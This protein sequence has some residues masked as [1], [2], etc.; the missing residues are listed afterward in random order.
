MN[1]F[2]HTQG[3]CIT[4]KYP[5]LFLPRQLLFHSSAFTRMGRKCTIAPEIETAA[6]FSHLSSIYTPFTRNAAESKRVQNAL[7]E[8]TKGVSADSVHVEL[9]EAN[10]LKCN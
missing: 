2:F 8:K 7:C 3:I 4:K 10:S 5:S 6:S 9:A 1:Y